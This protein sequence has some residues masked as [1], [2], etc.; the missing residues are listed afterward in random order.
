MS[1][2]IGIRTGLQHDGTYLYAI[3]ADTKVQAC[4]DII[5]A[6]VEGLFKDAP[7]R[8]GEAPKAL[9]VVRCSGEVEYT[10]IGFTGGVVEILGK[11]KQFVAS[12]IHPGTLREYEWTQKLRPLCDLPICAPEYISGLMASLQ[13][14][15]PEAGAIYRE[16]GARRDTPQGSL[17]GDPDT[18][19]AALRLIPNVYEPPGR[20]KFV[21]MA[22]AVR[23]ACQ[24]D[25]ERGLEL[26]VEW[27]EKANVPDP[28][29]DPEQTYKSIKAPF[30][31]GAPWLFELAEAADP[32][33][34]FKKADAC[35][36]P[37][38]D[39]VAA[40]AA[41]TAGEEALAGA[42]AGEAASSVFDDVEPIDIF[43]DADPSELDTPPDGAIPPIIGPWARDEARRKG[44][45]LFP[46]RRRLQRRLSPPASSASKAA[47]SVFRVMRPTTKSGRS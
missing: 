35:A 4:A 39:E 22:A 5:H 17:A 24:N 19:G 42:P 3:D 38:F 9:Y 33:G 37:W 47:V 23:G 40:A 18:V 13:G 30:A 15:L 28:Q 26:F 46:M 14:L 11:G 16:G 20:A 10:S 21:K 2:G 8:V 41:I 6:Q 12:A 44:V 36:L 43:G 27:A 1:A 29:D 45:P 31:V 34:K 7:T 32:T 25:Y